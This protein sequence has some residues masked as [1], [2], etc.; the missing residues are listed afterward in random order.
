MRVL[1]VDLRD[2]VHVGDELEIGIV[3]SPGYSWVRFLAKGERLD[4]ITN[5]DLAGMARFLAETWAKAD[6]DERAWLRVQFKKAFPEFA[7][8]LKSRSGV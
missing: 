7:A 2:Q 4:D 1:D 6:D 5:N 3:P 8:W